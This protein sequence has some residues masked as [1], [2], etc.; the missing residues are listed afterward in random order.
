MPV[1]TLSSTPKTLPLAF[2]VSQASSSPGLVR[3][4]YFAINLLCIY[5][6]RN[7]AQV[8][9]QTNI[10]RGFTLPVLLVLRFL[11]FAVSA[12]PPC[13]QSIVR[14][15]LA[16]SLCRRRH[17]GGRLLHS[18]QSHSVFLTLLRILH[19]SMQNLGLAVARVSQFTGWWI[20]HLSRNLVR[21]VAR[22]FQFTGWWILHP[23]WWVRISVESVNY[24]LPGSHSPPRSM[25][26]LHHLSRTSTRVR[27]SLR[28]AVFIGPGPGA[29]H[30][31]KPPEPVLQ[32]LT[33]LARILGYSDCKVTHLQVPHGRAPRWF[34]ALLLIY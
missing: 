9:T 33:L 15:S 28:D 4:P 13:W 34:G 16:L 21:A 30:K 10:P 18:L 17:V 20:L 26:L 11:A 27:S 6:S 5:A 22:V 3:L 14:H 29:F 7:T 23:S 2:S 25:R 31:V 12:F 8:P 24:L 32:L 1:L 19:R